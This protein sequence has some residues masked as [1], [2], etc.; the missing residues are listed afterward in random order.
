MV[1]RA[2]RRIQ[3]QENRVLPLVTATVVPDNYLE[4]C[5][6]PGHSSC[7]GFLTRPSI[8]AGLASSEPMVPPSDNEMEENSP[9]A[10]PPATARAIHNSTRSKRVGAPAGRSNTILIRYYYQGAK[11]V[12]A[13]GRTPG[14]T[15]FGPL[16]RTQEFHPGTPNQFSQCDQHL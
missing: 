11:G 8:S 5:S 3:R 2:S 6:W 4:R 10:S 1:S 16:Q 14:G 12:A 7:G 9:K 15:G 13:P